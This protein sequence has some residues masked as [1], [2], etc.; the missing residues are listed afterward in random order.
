[1]KTIELKKA[2]K[3][4]FGSVGNFAVLSGLS[5]WTITNAFNNR[6]AIDKIDF[7]LKEIELKFRTTDSK[8]EKLIKPEEREFVRL[9]L[10]AKFKSLQNFCNKNPKFSL[11]FVSNVINGRRKKK[12]QRFD[13]LLKKC[14]Q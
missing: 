4:K 9:M 6:I 13:S 3:T 1:M 10:V 8:N 5:Y 14:Q 7:V 11:T 2:I 12:D